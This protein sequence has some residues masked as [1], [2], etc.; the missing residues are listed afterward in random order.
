[1]FKYH[2]VLNSG[3]DKDEISVGCAFWDFDPNRQGL[4]L[5]TPEYSQIEFIPYRLSTATAPVISVIR[6]SIASISAFK[7]R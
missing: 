6:R 1:M 2:T 4:P 5:L 3:L 7:G